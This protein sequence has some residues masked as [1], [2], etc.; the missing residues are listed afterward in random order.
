M[1]NLKRVFTREKNNKPQTF[2]PVVIHPG[3]DV[4]IDKITVYFRFLE[5]LYYIYRL[6]MCFY[7]MLPLLV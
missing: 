4:P 3:N 2:F 6:T 1:T 5:E 7:F